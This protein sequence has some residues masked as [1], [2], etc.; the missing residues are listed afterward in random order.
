[1]PALYEFGQWAY[2][3]DPAS[4]RNQLRDIWSARL[5]VDAEAEIPEES[6]SDTRYQPFLQ[7][8]GSRVR[9]KN[10]VGFIQNDAELIEIYPKVFR[11]TGTPSKAMMLKHVFYWFRYCRKWQFP[12]TQAGLHTTDIDSFPELIIHLMAKQFLEAV[13]SQP[14]S[15]YQSVEE[16]LSTPRGSINFKRYLKNGFA[17]GNLHKVDCDYEPFSFNNRINRIIKRCARLLLNQTRFSENVRLLQETI[18]ILD[19]V[20]DAS[21]SIHDVES[22]SIN[23]FFTDYLL[24]MDACRSI[25]SQQLYSSQLNDLSQW[26]LLFPMEYIFEDFLAGFLETH[27]AAEWKVKYQKSDKYLSDEPKAFQMQH[28]IFLTHKATSRQIIVDAKYKL[29]P[30]NY[31]NELKKGISQVDL[32]QMTAYAVKRGCNDVLLLYPNITEDEAQ[33]DEFKIVSNFAGK[34]VI[35]VTAAEIPFWSMEDFSGLENSLRD[36]LT[37]VLSQP[38]ASTES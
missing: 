28:D 22:V 27:F 38:P 37:G 7:F 8:D 32:Y 21:I 18:F 2:I 25:L 24:V 3:T 5:F 14:L 1:M 36:R 35:N 33:V 34:D 11:G 20:D 23:S 4:L 6:E 31:K 12:F 15:I 19:E 29:R 13:S 9:A 30:E 17:T 26:C 10:F 16:S